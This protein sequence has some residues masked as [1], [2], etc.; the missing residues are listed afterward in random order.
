MD[1]KQ[2][3]GVF[4]ALAQETRLRIVRLLVQAGPDGLAAGAIGEAMNGASS[5]L[6][7][8]HLGHLEQAGLIA[9]RRTGRS[10]L[11]TADYAALSDVIAFLMRDCCQGHPEVCAPALAAISCCGPGG[12]GMRHAKC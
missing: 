5:S 1:E 9:S 11:Y 8:F 12:K 6:M 2:A 10:I 7:S 3:L 4:A